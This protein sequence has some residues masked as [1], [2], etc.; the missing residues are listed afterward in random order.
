M[1]GKNGVVTNSIFR[2]TAITK[3]CDWFQKN[4]WMKKDLVES[5]ITGAAGN[6]EYFIYCVK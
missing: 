4:S 3:V 2:K 5:P 1:I 6:K